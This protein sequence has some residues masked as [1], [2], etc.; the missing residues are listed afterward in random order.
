MPDRSDPRDGYE[1]LFFEKLARIEDHHF[2]FRFRNRVLM[3]LVQDVVAPLPPG[4]RV[5]EAG[6]GDG[7]VLRFLTSASQQGVVTGIDLFEEGLRLAKR[8][9]NAQLVRGDIHFPPFRCR[10]DVVGAFDVI[11]HLRDD[12]QPLRD[13]HHLLADNG[14]LLL[15]VPAHLSLWSYFDDASGHCRRY[16]SKQLESVL[17]EC[18]FRVEYMTEFM[19]VLY[20]LLWLGR[21]LATWIDNPKSAPAD[22]L[23]D[24]RVIPVLNQLLLM[25]LSWELPLLRRRVRI[26]LG[27]SLLVIARRA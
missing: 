13:L 15:T 24:L 20:P 4:F 5:L 27:S 18:G 26:P 22:S 9:S 23:P 3:S 19:M 10:F 25:L 17:A 2:W 12:C 1:P 6:C 7:N 11:E 14:V 8:R 16:S 21:R